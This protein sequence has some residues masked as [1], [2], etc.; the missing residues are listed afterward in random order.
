MI[1]FRTSTLLRIFHGIEN[2]TFNFQ[3]Y[4]SD[5]SNGPWL[6]SALLIDSNSIFLNNSKEFIK[7][8]LEI[9]TEAPEILDQLGLLLYVEVAIHDPI[10]PVISDSARNVLSRFP[11]WT[12]MY[13]DSIERATPEL[14]TPVSNAG[15]FINSLVSEYLDDFNSLIDKHSLDAFIST[16]DEDMIDWVYASYNI[17]ATASV[18]LGDGIQ[19]AKAPSLDAFYASKK[20]DYIYYHNLI[21]S[22]IITLQ[23]FNQLLING[24]TYEQDPAM[25]FNM[26]DE[27]GVRVNLPRLYLEPNAMYKKRILDVYVNPPA[28]NN[29]AFKKTLRRELDIW[30][31]YGATPDSNYIGATPEIMEMSDIENSTPY[32][33]FN[34]NPTDKF[35]EFVKYINQTYPSNMGYVSWEEGIW[36]YAGLNG[37][38]VGRIPAVYDVATPDS[39]HFQPGVGDFQDAKLVLPRDIIDSATTSFS[40]Y[41]KANGFKVTGTQDV[42]GPVTVK[43]S[44]KAGY[45]QTVPDP[46]V[47]NPN[48]AT[49]FNGGVALVYEVVIPPNQDSATPQTFYTN[50]SYDDREDFFVYNYYSQTS[51]ASPEYNYIN[52]VNSDGLTNTNLVFREKTYDYVYVDSSSTPA[53]PSIDISKATSITVRN[54]VRWNPDTDSY[55]TV[56]TGNYR[57]AFNDDSRGYFVNPS[58]GQSI[59]LATPNIN[60]YNANLKIGSTA[61]GTKQISGFTNE[62][63][64]TIIVNDKNDISE[65]QDV[66]LPSSDIKKYLAFPLNATP[67][68][69]YITNTKVSPSPIYGSPQATVVEEVEHGGIGYNPIDNTEYYV[70]SSPNILIS[71]YA[72]I[73][74][75]SSPILV[76]YFE[77][78]TVN[79]SSA[80]Q[81]FIVSAATPSLYYPF[82]ENV[83]SSIEDNELKSTPMILGF[84][85]HLGNVYKNNELIEDSG[86]SINSKIKDTY[87]SSF[88][89]TRESFGIAPENTQ[90]YLI[91]EIVPVSETG[92]VSLVSNKTEVLPSENIPNLITIQKTY[93]SELIEEIYDE[94][95]DQYFY[96]DIEIHAQKISDIKYVEGFDLESKEPHLH[97]GWLYLSDE[98]YYIY[99]K[100]VTE[101]FYGQFFEIDLQE[102]PRQ[103]APVIVNVMNS[104]ATVAYQ[105]LIFPDE[106]TPGQPTIFNKETITGS[107]DL[108]LY[109]ANSNIDEILVFDTY[110]GLYL[111]EDPILVGYYVWSTVDE[112]GNYVFDT[113]LDGEYYVFNIEYSIDG[114]RLQILSAETGESIIIPGRN[115]E[116]TYFI[117]ESFY[118]DKDFY[119]ESTDDYGARMF[120]SSTPDNPALYEITYE[121]AIDEFSTPSGI[122]L[123]SLDNPLNEGFIFV[124]DSEYDFRT[125]LVKVSPTQISDNLDDLIYLSIV[126]L[127]TN[128]NP[129]PHQ[130][131]R[132]YSDLLIADSEYITT[133]KYGFANVILRYNGPI[134]TT[135]TEA[136]VFIESSDIASSTP[137]FEQVKVSV[138]KTSE[139][140]GKSLKSIAEKTVIKANFISDNRIKGYIRS[141]DGDVANKVVYWRKARSVFG[142]M[143]NVPYLISSATPD[144]DNTSGIVYTDSSGNFEIGSFQAQGRDR[145][146]YWYVVVES[147]I[148]ST[149]SA[150][151]ITIVGDINYWYESYDNIDYLKEI[152]TLPE[153]YSALVDRNSAIIQQPA[154]R[155]NYHDMSYDEYAPATLNWNPPKWM[156]IKYYEQYQMGLFGSTPNI[157]STYVNTVNDY[158]ES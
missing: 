7:I 59:S 14:A 125:A 102:V 49:P 8:E 85:D 62:I 76:E 2:P 103:G 9:F 64:D 130:T 135:S 80:P 151:P 137:Y 23:K 21:D 35:V 139:S 121:S 27:F 129:K 30:R 86:R 154:F 157:V 97:T 36:D 22:Q 28:V 143:E 126:S 123:S 74:N 101:N 52:I 43:Y 72:S 91:T 32:F 51:A 16:A 128:K 131:F 119:Y 40:G 34:G 155:Y 44:Y 12:A 65:T 141:D 146:G 11:T 152:L 18:V 54:R 106:A 112:D 78:S 46:D 38:G 81:A 90:D 29:E 3:V 104:D 89:L 55:V 17:P 140:I 67:T 19:L 77:S 116:V 13:E 10:S 63:N 120:L 113:F 134:P 136:T 58:V 158:E 24:N 1:L 114:N 133:N 144:T 50:L 25:L 75:L 122:S 150:T 109:L 105:N 148:S 111:I 60:Y 20:T 149:P 138:S 48:S 98:D 92:E 107:N 37:E 115:Y 87:L 33:A 93:A 124:S 15:K 99:A 42:F 4:E 53:I 110:T 95:S 118:V 100:P 127:D 117:R 84:I 5:S 70:P 82:D 83:W 39:I 153:N 57:V 73:D 156:P 145:S 45:N 79:Y 147:E 47:N 96:S 94:D 31:A 88:S 61:Y 108:A 68:S 69:L 26:F 66:L 71:H 142:A 56:P 41:F 6:K 132:V